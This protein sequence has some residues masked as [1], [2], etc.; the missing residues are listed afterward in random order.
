MSNRAFA[1]LMCWML[2]VGLL[3]IGIDYWTVQSPEIAVVG[4]LIMAVPIVWIS[5]K[6]GL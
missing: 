1:K 4:A 3:I 2:N 5:W 6:E